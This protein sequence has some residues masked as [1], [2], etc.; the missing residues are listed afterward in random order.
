MKDH[1]MYIAGAWTDGES[2]GTVPEGT[3]G[4]PDNSVF[5]TISGE[6]P[7]G[8]RAIALHCSLQLPSC[9]SSTHEESAP[10]CQ[11]HARGWTYGALG[12]RGGLQGGQ[13]RAGRRAPP[14]CTG[15]HKSIRCRRQH[16]R[17]SKHPSYSL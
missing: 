2:I 14:S 11:G 7:C 12:S 10:E 15:N 16:D 13:Y 1:P 4:V 5:R 17:S 9:P 8:G 6:P 3:L